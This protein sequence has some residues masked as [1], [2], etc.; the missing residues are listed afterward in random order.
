[1]LSFMKFECRL[2]TSK[3]FYCF[4]SIRLDLFDEF[5]TCCISCK[6]LPA[7]APLSLYPI[8]APV[9]RWPPW[10][11]MICPFFPSL[12]AISP[13]GASRGEMSRSRALGTPLRCPRA[14]GEPWARLAVIDHERSPSSS[15][16]TSYSSSK[17]PGP[18]EICSLKVSA[19]SAL[20]S[21]PDSAKSVLN[22]F[23]I[24]TIAS[25]SSCSWWS[26]SRLATSSTCKLFYIIGGWF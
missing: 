9:A 26:V 20:A 15:S 2:W 10:F 18:S 3:L 4:K 25:E 21:L 19:I 22:L 16:T 17:P 12:G 23:C 24:E 5:S 7:N 6:P 8:A 14:D 13:A 11:L 1:M